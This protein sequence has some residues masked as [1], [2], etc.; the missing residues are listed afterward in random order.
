MD[1]GADIGVCI[2]FVKPSHKIGKNIISLKG[3]GTKLLRCG[4]DKI[5]QYRHRISNDNEIG[6]LFI[7]FNVEKQ[8]VKIHSHKI[9]EP[10][11]IR[12]YKKFAKRD[13]VVD[14]RINDMIS[15]C[16]E[17]FEGSK[18]YPEKRPKQQQEKM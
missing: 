1:R 14:R 9:D 3:H 6:V 17:A 2:K 8:A 18:G 16:P 4:V 11:K 7:C 15:A 13:E 5:Y 12:N 10:K